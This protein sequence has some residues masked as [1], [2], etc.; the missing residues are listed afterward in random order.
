MST[1]P[2][3]TTPK[4]LT[5][6]RFVNLFTTDLCTAKGRSPWLFA[7][8]KQQPGATVLQA[9]AALVVAVTLRNNEPRLVL[10]R[11]FRAPL[12][13][14]ELSLPAG[15]VDPGES[16][17]ATALREFHEETGMTLTR[18]VH[19]SPPLASSA[20]LTD[21]TVALVYAEAEGTPSREHQT[22]HEEIEVLLV[23]INELRELLA[24][25]TGDIISSRL[26]PILVG[27]VSQ[28][29]IALPNFDR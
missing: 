2:H 20:G 6:E 17:A 23:S 12:G 16:P 13:A 5:D 19:V 11:E 18:V 28:G 9:D 7:S 24:V 26:Y 14:H 10:T 22:E 4:R 15:L 3:I 27:Y 29:A 1:F 8:R 25:P 21:E